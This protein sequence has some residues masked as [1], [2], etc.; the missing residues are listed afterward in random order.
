MPGCQCHDRP[1]TPIHSNGKKGHLM[2][3]SFASTIDVRQIAPQE[4]HGLIFERL[5]ALPAGE[6]LLLINDHDPVPL[7]NQVDRQWPGQFEC[8][9][10]DAG[11]ALWRLEMRKA[12]APTK[13]RS[14]SCCSGGACGG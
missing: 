9:Y 2:T 11:P 1:T 8:A 10:L 4:R 14:D 7:R 5:A 13:A 6:A 3:T 12:A